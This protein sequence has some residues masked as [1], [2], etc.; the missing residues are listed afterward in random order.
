MDVA[1][2]APVQQSGS[3]LAVEIENVPAT[4][5]SFSVT[6]SV[7]IA[8]AGLAFFA[9]GGVAGAGL[10]R[11][12]AVTVGWTL[13]AWA[14]LRLPNGVPWFLGVLCVFIVVQLLVPALRRWSSVPGKSIEPESGRSPAVATLLIGTLLWI[15]TGCAGVPV[16]SSGSTSI[17]SVRQD[18]RVDENFAF[19][20]AKIRW[21]ATNGAMLPVLA[22]PA[23]LTKILYPEA[24][25]TLVQTTVNGKRIQQLRADRAGSYDIEVHYQLQVTKWP[26]ESVFALPTVSGLINQLNVTVT[27][28]DVDVFSP[29]GVGRRNKRPGKSVDFY[30]HNID[31]TI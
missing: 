6:G 4:T 21:Q 16:S 14:T 26:A 10:K 13:L 22:E 19:A 20:T 8:V 27:G 7:L 1:F 17:E 23:V 12:A 30:A 29:Q 3:A 11:S 31:A 2:L 9:I 5:S 18:I 24:S 15:G 28:M 25:L